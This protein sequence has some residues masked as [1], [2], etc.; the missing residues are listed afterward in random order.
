M[1][2]YMEVRGTWRTPVSFAPEQ[3]ANRPGF[4]KRVHAVDDVV[5]LESVDQVYVRVVK[6]TVQQEASRQRQVLVRG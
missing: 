2:C 6:A 5:A 1:L 4:A 3:V